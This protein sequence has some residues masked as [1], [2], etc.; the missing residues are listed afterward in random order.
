MRP[1]HTTFPWDLRPGV[2]LGLDST[3]KTGSRT[4]VEGREVGAWKQSV[5]LGVSIQNQLSLFLR[6]REAISLDHD[7]WLQFTIR[8]QDRKPPGWC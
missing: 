2:K 7:L 3:V 6:N 1:R 5:T 4:R 8:S